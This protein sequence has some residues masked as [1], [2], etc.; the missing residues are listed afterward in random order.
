MLGNKDNAENAQA[1]SVGARRSPPRWFFPLD[2]TSRTALG[3]GWAERTLAE[4]GPDRRARKTKTPAIY[5]P[6]RRF[7]VN[8]GALGRG[9]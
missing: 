9:I 5:A 2:V 3:R 1:V 4:F 8:G 7:E 6:R